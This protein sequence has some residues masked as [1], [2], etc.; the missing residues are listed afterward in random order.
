MFSIKSC[1]IS[2]LTAAVKANVSSPLPGPSDACTF[3]HKT[4]IKTYACAENQLLDNQCSA[5]SRKRGPQTAVLNKKAE[6]FPSLLHFCR[7]SDVDANGK[8]PG[9]AVG[10]AT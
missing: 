5:S 7:A 2:L 9:Q 8:I 1:S 10:L 6:T 3:L 4:G